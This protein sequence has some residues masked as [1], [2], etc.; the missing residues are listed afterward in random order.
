MLRSYASDPC[1][2]LF[3]TPSGEATALGNVRASRHFPVDQETVPP[4]Q[5]HYLREKT[6]EELFSG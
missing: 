5:K 4:P 1:G 3:L 6:P 2:A